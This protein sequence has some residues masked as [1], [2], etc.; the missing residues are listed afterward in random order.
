MNIFVGLALTPEGWCK[1]VRLTVDEVGRISAVEA[2]VEANP[3][4][5]NLPKRIL[6]PA[7]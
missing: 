6:L 3:D 2:G 5:Q 1:N 4:D 7:L